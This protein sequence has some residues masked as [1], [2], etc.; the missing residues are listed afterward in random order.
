MRR[1]NIFFK[2][3]HAGILEETGGDGTRFVYNPDWSEQIAC[4]LPVERRE[5]EWPAGLHPFFQH[6][7]PEG[8]LRERQARVAHVEEEDDLG[9]LLRYGADCIGAVGVRGDEEHPEPKGLD[10][11]TEAATR[12]LRTVSGLQKKL[13]AVRDG[14]AFR[15]AAAAGPAP[16]I[17]KFNSE[18]EPTLVRNEFLSL[19][20]TASVLG[21]DEVTN[22]ELGEVEDL[23]EVALVLHRFDRSSH[24]SKLRLEDCAQI[25]AKPRGRDYAGKYE[26]AYEDVADSIRRYSARPDIDIFRLFRRIITYAILGNCDAHLK[27]F[28]LLETESGLRLSPAYDVLNTAIY[29]DYSQQFALS[30]GGVW[31]QLEEVDRTVLE[32][33]GAQ[34]GL[35][36]AAVRAGFDQVRRG[37][38]RASSVLRPP[39]GEAPDGFVSRFA[40]I[41]SRGRMRMFG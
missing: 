16:Y 14:A 18:S 29:K 37:V 13:L 3:R 32:K 2:D 4:A 39:T 28:S 36:P 19:R 12:G 1:A 26:A 31:R 6:L 22:F 24:G 23:G 38:A 35:T 7:A 30:M 8:W 15:P 20:W 25:L 11:A 17:A 33:L 40:E 34:I 9:I 5:H 21:T 27:N 10:P 41:V